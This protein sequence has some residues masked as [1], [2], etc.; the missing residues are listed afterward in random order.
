MTDRMDSAVVRRLIE[1]GSS[2][3]PLMLLL[4]TYLGAAFHASL[5]GG[6]HSFMRPHQERLREMLNGPP[7][8]AH[9]R[10]PDL[11]IV[12]AVSRELE[13][14]YRLAILDSFLNNL[15]SYALA[16]RP[17]KAIGRAQMQ[18]SVLLG[19]TRAEV[20]NE[21]IARRTK[22]LSRENFGTRIQA[23]RDITGT[24]FQIPKGD[25]DELKRLS[26]IRNAIVH[27]GSAYQ[28]TVD[29]DLR[30]HSQAHAQTVTMGWENFDVI[31]RVAATMYEQYVTQFVG[32]DINA[33]ERG[34]LTALN[35]SSSAVKH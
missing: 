27:E 28:F 12:L 10:E 14:V 34:T 6:V 8:N 23:L 16:L 33:L 1:I 25:S 9:L 22:S 2:G 4:V 24:S 15:T 30:I 13:L 32:R 18:A 3:D 5:F 17:S 21:Y 19:K 26:N 20:V 7:S 29:N 11:P 35:P 31:N